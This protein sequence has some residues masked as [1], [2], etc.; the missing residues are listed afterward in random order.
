MSD[1]WNPFEEKT[2]L[3]KLKIDYK[4]KRNEQ[5]YNFLEI[6]IFPLC[7]TFLLSLIVL[8]VFI[9]WYVDRTNNA[10]KN[11][12]VLDKLNSFTVPQYF[13]LKGISSENIKQESNSK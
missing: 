5:I 7:F 9:A 1:S 2:K 13:E 12:V 8:S 10:I 6:N 11:S 3:E 4:Q